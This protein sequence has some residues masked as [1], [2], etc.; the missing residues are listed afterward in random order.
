MNQ[1]SKF[2]QIAIISYDFIEDSKNS[3]PLMV[4]ET[5]KEGTY[6][7]DVVVYCAN[8]SHHKKQFVEFYNRDFQAV[9][10]P[11][12]SRNISLMRIFSYWI[13]C[14]KI[15]FK[16]DLKNFEILFY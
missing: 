16:Q 7:M 4:Y 14:A 8:F 10:V 6:P 5:L 3:R 2:T 9:R 15:I 12:Y 11:H 13:F 1:S